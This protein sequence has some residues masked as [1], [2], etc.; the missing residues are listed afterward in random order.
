MNDSGGGNAHRL[1]QGRIGI[2][3]RLGEIRLYSWTLNALIDKSHFS[4]VTNDCD[5]LAIPIE[6]LSGD[7]QALFFP[8][9]PVQTPPAMLERAGAMLVYTPETFRN[10]YVD[11]GAFT[12]FASYLGKFS[13]KSRSTLIRKVRKF[14][15]LCGDTE[16]FREFSRPDEFDEFFAL[17]G[18]ISKETY[19]ER[20]L[21]AGLP[22][23]P[24]FIEAT[25]KRAE[26]GGAIGWLL[27]CRGKPVAYV[28]SRVENGIATYDYVGYL[29]EVHHLSP[30]TV[31]Q[32][33][34]LESLFG[35]RKVRMFDFTEGEGEH[36][37]FFSTGSQLCSK[38]YVFR[39]SIKVEVLVGLR[40]SLN[41]SVEGLGRV[42]A[43]AGLKARLR[44]LIRR[45]A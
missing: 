31:L 29:T 12:D 38:T 11:L 4:E 14:K 9:R 40:V 6:R 13:A 19:Q 3:F 27:S 1:R 22:R 37:R 39:R 25:K 23:D 43:R 34:I 26:S 28:L 42:L 24:A 32:Y 15:E 16:G 36:K 17:A 8:R 44:A 7:I 41:L 30:G 18:Q 33:L 21:D 2:S 20:L 5:A 10:F 45:M 35:S